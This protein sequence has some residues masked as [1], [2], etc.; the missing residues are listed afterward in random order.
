MDPRQFIRDFQQSSLPRREH[1]ERVV[2]PY[3]NPG[4]NVRHLFSG[5][6]DTWRA[7]RWVVAVTD[8]SILVVEAAPGHF[9]WR[10]LRPR[11]SF[12]LPR[13]TRIGPR[14]RLRLYVLD[15]RKFMVS[16]REDERAIAAADAEMGFP[17]PT[18][19]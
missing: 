18:E 19:R 11:Q 7:P 12:R 2:E 9:I 16:T 5:V 14:H 1:L 8:T 13:A 6:R 10:P 15:G 4:E 3:L 17:A